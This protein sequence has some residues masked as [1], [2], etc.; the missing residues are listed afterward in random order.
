VC[1]A[2]TNPHSCVQCL[3]STDCQSGDVCNQT[4]HTCQA[5]PE[6]SEGQACFTNTTCNAGLLCIDEGGAHPVCRKQCDPSHDTVCSGVSS[7]DV[8]EWLNFDAGGTL[9]GICERG[10][11]HGHPGDSCDP[12]M[13]DSCE[14]NLLCQPT[15]ASSGK[16]EALCH[17]GGSCA[18]G[19]CNSVLGAL[20]ASGKPLYLG[21]CASGAS[22]WGVSCVTDTSSTGPNCGDAL[23][24]AGT[25]G[26]LFCTPSALPAEYPAVSIAATCQF[27][28]AGQS[29]VG[30]AGASCASLGGAACRTG[31]CLGDGPQTCFSGCQFNADCGRDGT[32][33]TNCYAITYSAG[34][35]VGT[36]GTC[37]P[38]CRDD[39]DCP[40][41]ACQ[42]SPVFGGSSWK[43]ICAPA[44][45]T[46]KPGSACSGGA[47]CESGVCIT[48]STLEAIEL[49]L[50]VSGF[51]ATDG[52]CLGAC[53]PTA[54][55]CAAATTCSTG[56]A[57]PL[58]PT[59]TGD[60]GVVG[61]VNPGICFGTSCTTNT[62]CAGLSSDSTTPR[63]CAPYKMSTLASVDTSK[64]CSS[65]SQCAGSTS[66]LA[67][68]NSSTNNP[69]PGS[70]YGTNAGIYGPNAKCRAVSW[71]L[72]CAPSLGATRGG[73]GASCTGAT[74]CQTGHCINNGSS[75]YCFGGCSGNS[76]CQGSTTCQTGTYLGLTGKHC[77]P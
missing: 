21:V 30:G 33:N 73:P 34:A 8:C 68:C 66:W 50:T 38:S 27:G 59:T 70:A 2:A 13:I 5:A 58:T 75:S 18:S 77:M 37:E 28:P 71:A 52:F 46:G 45:G 24:N 20:D 9:I 15:S 53:L 40:A 76:D 43:A 25:G 6:G 31:L 26:A 22:S 42:P 65:D 1:N 69:N 64:N 60:L 56:A 47:A 16:C 49:G 14:W 3:V 67:T 41:G 72:G 32:G 55:D 23:S 12:A 51:T 39:L 74:G 7:S 54:S 29:A 17:P 35:A 4:S 61:K 44:S 62:N 11:G 63:V 48:A 57:L 10:N 19:T 36:V